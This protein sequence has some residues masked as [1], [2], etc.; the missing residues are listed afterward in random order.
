M[1]EF[2]LGMIV[3]AIDFALFFWLGYWLARRYL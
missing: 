2:A 3:G 1:T